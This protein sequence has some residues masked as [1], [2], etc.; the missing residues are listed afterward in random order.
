MFLKGYNHAKKCDRKVT[1]T[2]HKELDLP[3]QQVSLLRLKL[4]Y[5]VVTS[6]KRGEKGEIGAYDWKDGSMTRFMLVLYMCQ[7][8]HSTHTISMILWCTISY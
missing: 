2:L 6:S 3:V 5:Q 1:Q 8:M 4:R 7:N